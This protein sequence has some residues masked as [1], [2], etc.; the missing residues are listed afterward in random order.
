MDSE[1]T[2]PATWLDRP[3]FPFLPNF[4]I[5]TFLVT[6]ILIL[7]VLSRFVNLGARVMSHDEVNH[8]VP[9][10]SLYKGQGYA[11][12][13]ITHGPLQFHMMAFS[14][15]LLGDSD[16]SSRAPDALVSVATIAFVLFA[17]RR[18]LG[19]TG[20]LIAGFLYLISPF[21]M[22][23]GRYTRNEVYGGL[24]TVL[25][26]YGA[27]RYLENGGRKWLYL[28]TV[29]MAFHFTDKATAYIYNAE[30]L[31]F[32]GVLFLVSVI[33]LPWPDERR[34]WTFVFLTGSALALI[35]IVVIFAALFPGT[36]TTP[37]AG[38]E[39][40]PPTGLTTDKI[41]EIG[42]V[43]LALIAGL[44]AIVLLVRSLGWKVIR[45]LR[46]FDLIML[47]GVLTLPLLGSLVMRMFGFDPLDYSSAGMVRTTIFLVPL[48]L[49]SIALGLWWKPRFYVTAA[50][51]FFSIFTVFYTTF[52]TNG[53]GFFMGLVA[54]LGYWLPQQAVNRG[55]Q[56]LYYFALIQVPIYEYLAALGA[57]LA[58]ILAIRNRLFTQFARFAPARQPETAP[59]EN[60]IP[61]AEDN[62]SALF[63]RT[64]YEASDP[65]ENSDPEI[66]ENLREAETGELQ[67]ATAE[68]EV[69]EVPG[70]LVEAEPEIVEEKKTYAPRIP[71]A[72]LLLY[73]SV[74]SLIAFSLAGER[75]PW[76][77]VHIAGSM[78]LASGW[79]LGYLVDTTPWR[80]IANRKGLLTLLLIPIIFT[81]LGGLF[82]SLLGAQPPFQGN[83]VPQLE[84]S[85]TFITALAALIASGFGFF[86]LL[87]DWQSHHLARLL[88]LGF[89]VICAVL[90]ARTAYNA[91]FINYDLPVEFMVYAH[92]A[93]G[94]KEVLA[95][96]EDISQRLT[97]GKNLVIAYDNETNYPWWWYLRD[98]PNKKYY[99]D[100]PTR[101]IL[102]ADVITVGDPNYSKIDALLKNNTNYI[103]Y[104]YP[105]LWW[106]MQDY[107]NLDWQRVWYAISTPQMRQALFNI[108][109]NRD[110]T[111]Y[112]QATGETTLTLP[113][114]SPAA[115]MRVYIRKDIVAK[116]WDYGPAPTTAAPTPTDPYEAG[117]LKLTPDLVTGTSGNELGQF[118]APR[119]LALAP[120]GTVYVADSRN[121]R[122][123][124]LSADLKTVI[125]SWGTFADALKGAA[126]GGTFNEPWDVIVGPDGSVYVADTFNM[127]IQKFTP[128]G[129]FIKMWGF[130]G[131]AETLDAIWGP[132]GLA[133]DSKGRLFVTDTGNKRVVVYDADGNGLFAFGTSGF[134][135][136]QLDEPVGIAIDKQ[137]DVFIADT[138]NQRI[139]EFSPGPGGDS[140]LPKNMWDLQAWAGQSLDNKPYLALDAAGNVYATDPEGGRVLIFSS[141]GKYLRGIG[142]STE[143]QGNFVMPA[144]VAVDSEGQV[145]ITDAILNEVMRFTLPAAAPSQ[146]PASA[147]PTEIQPSP[148]DTSAGPV[149]GPGA[150]NTP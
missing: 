112:A 129:T 62:L 142:Q 110:Y 60:S 67:P 119:G 138:W 13:P 27:L 54:L 4:K 45:G 123:V 59:E 18:Y 7:A 149:I 8:V 14:Y 125:K 116:M 3:I 105:R 63:N 1:Q 29:V 94:P 40:P 132:R 86:R 34:R 26:L 55:G 24:W 31:I 73:W 68:A 42:A 148:T 64:R 102:T 93:P 81:S 12:D 58:F 5:E 106:P 10:Y 28:L 89:F 143:G 115:R 6:V 117:L 99:G 88:T 146:P 85:A 66:E 50:V 144:G 97:Q 65:E 111:L 103:M 30:L 147:S 20:A 87:K 118:N 100:T 91:S 77:T 139:Q 133:F 79:G 74:M 17:F 127:R 37:P 19:R 41:A 95:Q 131:Q 46:S 43:G 49:I 35:L 76:L 23:Y 83:T 137:D 57:V 72:A 96:L 2:A 51:I 69:E 113:T 84:S 71:V 108:W 39:A 70:Q 150:T 140:Y 107:W 78:L 36:A 56:P 126:P 22:F 109:L 135:Q 16:F 80:A 32:L 61:E 11:F 120:D 136:G 15:F 128:D 33:R 122:I 21:M 114:W 98:W 104:E 92:A 44:Y 121:N 82:G 53:K 141:V 48:F 47:A 75:M 134:A 52:F 124:H 101:D 9:A 145:W 130:F 25:L 38:V 90:T